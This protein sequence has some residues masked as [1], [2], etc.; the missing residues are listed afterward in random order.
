MLTSLFALSMLRIGETGAAPA[1]SMSAATNKSSYCIR[2]PVT[3]AGTINESG[4][5]AMNY[6]VGVE[7]DSPR[8]GAI[9][10]RTISIGNPAP[11]P[12]LTWQ[13][14][15]SAVYV[16]D[17]DGTQTNSITLNSLMSLHATLKNN[18][19]QEYNVVVTGTVFDGDLIPI[20]AVGSQ[21]TMAPSQTRT[22]SWS[23]PVPEWAYSGEALATVNVYTDFPRNNGTS[24]VPE[25]RYVFYL[26]R[27]SAIKTPYSVLPATDTSAPGRY[28]LAFRMPPDIYTQPGTYNAYVTTVSP[29]TPYLRSAATTSFNLLQYPS[30]PQAAFTYMPLQIYGGMSVTFDASSSSAEGPNVTITQYEWT[31][32]DPNNP[33]HTI[34]TSPTLIHSFTASGTYVAQ[35]NVTNSVGLWSTTSKPVVVLPDYGPTANFTWTPQK[36]T[37]NRTA[38]F[39]ASSSQAW[40]EHTNRWIRTNRKLHVELW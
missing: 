36:P 26:T 8:G 1:V 2:E 9:F 39:D 11:A 28:Q 37:M 20:I 18:Y 27:N 38:I 19:P 13:L 23:V 33:V 24:I 17:S 14:Q 16:E 22:V 35:L 6:L 25:A 7:A 34:Q 12:P 3:L 15:I 21:I 40:M 5:P 29:A 32:N 30:P 10:Y 4:Q 31:I